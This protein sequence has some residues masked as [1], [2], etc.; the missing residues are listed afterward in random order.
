MKLLHVDLNNFIC[1]EAVEEMI[2]IRV[3]VLRKCGVF[4]LYYYSFNRE[5]VTR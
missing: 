2:I 4:F 1:D 3:E 5:F